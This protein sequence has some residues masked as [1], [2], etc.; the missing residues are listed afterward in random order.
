VITT[1]DDK[2]QGYNCIP[3][4][5]GD[6]CP[7]SRAVYQGDKY[8]D[9]SFMQHLAHEL[10]HTIHLNH[11]YDFSSGHE[12]C[13]VSEHDY[14]DDLLP[15]NA[16]YCNPPAPRSDCDA[17]LQNDTSKTPPNKD[18]AYLP[19]DSWTNNLMN[20]YGGRYITPKQLGKV[21]RA[22]ATRSLGQAST[23]YSD[24]PKEITQNETWDFPMQ[25]YSS[26]VVKAGNT[27]TL[28]CELRMP[29]E[30]RILVE[31]GA[32]LIIDGGHVTKRALD[33]WWGGVYVAG[34]SYHSQ[35]TTDQGK[36]TIIN[37]GKIS[38]ARDAITNIGVNANGGWIWGTT[39]GII[40]ANDA[41]FENNRRDVQLLAY[42]DPNFANAPYQATFEKCRFTRTDDFGIDAMIQSI[43]MWEVAGVKIEGCEFVNS[44]TGNFHYEG[45]GIFTM[46]ASYRVHEFGFAQDGCSFS[47]YADAIRSLEDFSVAFPI[48]VVGATFTDNIHGIYLRATENAKIAHNTMSVRT[49][50]SYSP[51]LGRPFQNKAYGIYFDFSNLFLVHDNT[52]VSA[53]GTNHLA[54]GIIVKDN[55]GANDQPYHNI[56]DNFKYGIQALGNNRNSAPNSSDYGLTFICNGFG[57]SNFNLN[58]IVVDPNGAIAGTQGTSSK[59][60]NNRFSTATAVTHIDNLG[61]NVKYPYGTS[62]SRVVPINYAGLTLDPQQITAD[63]VGN[64]MPWPKPSIVGN[65]GITISDIQAL[66]TSMQQDK[67]LRQQLIDE[68][69]PAQLEAL[70]LFADDQ[71]DYQHLYIEMM[72]M[73]PYVSEENLLNLVSLTGFPELAL[74]NIM[75]ANPH[76]SRSG[77]VWDALVNRE[78]ALSQQTLND[79][80]A[81]LQTITAKDI[82]DMDIANQQTESEYLSFQ[83]MQYYAE[84]LQEN[85]SNLADLK[86][87]LTY[88]DEAYFRYA[89][90]DLYLAEKNVTDATTAFD[91]IPMQCEMGPDE[92]DEYNWLDTYYGAFMPLIANDTRMDQLSVGTLGQLENIA[93]N[94]VGKAVGKA[95]ALLEL[96]GAATEYYEPILDDD[97]SYK[98]SPVKAK[99]PDVVDEAF[100]LYPNPAKDHTILQWNWLE[101]GLNEG[102]TLSITNVTGMLIKTVK[103]DDPKVNT[104]LIQMDKLAPGV[105]IISAHQEGQV[106]YKQKFTL[107]D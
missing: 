83:L 66:E 35:N 104:S 26:L 58:D 68:G 54:A 107:T 53:D 2:Q 14:M 27:L 52:I 63:Y 29:E 102:F 67:V 21:H 18:P 51:P 22:F 39:G 77:A 40:Y 11:V 41:D 87:H 82:L 76:S 30:G 81:E 37:E 94:G 9:W 80:Q 13:S 91:N 56:I 84:N 6:G 55:S 49:N 75:V 101:A 23:G 106:L 95:M 28:K 97:G 89:L 103:V 25:L 96:N 59:L 12:K 78:P 85:A 7:V 16:P 36:I 48:T 65:P 34:S 70:I 73:S 72:D 38:W 74:R 43:T 1:D 71:Q 17:C 5:T 99:R 15:V 47:G 45:G 32:H 98:S 90:V 44:N 69:S 20:A 64:C 3:A 92:Q 19:D 93:N 10:G 88:R 62:D 31:P 100:K 46:Q 8:R 105:Y 24:T 4:S 61:P 50:H 86:T 57:N 42:N 79:I 60:P 33:D